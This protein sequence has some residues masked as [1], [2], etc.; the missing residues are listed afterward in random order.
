MNILKLL[1]SSG[2]IQYNGYIARKFGVSEAIVLGELCSYANMYHFQEF[3]FTQDKIRYRTA[4]SE[5]QVR[6]ALKTLESNK[7][8]TITKKGNPCK[9]WYFLHGDILAD[10]LS[11]DDSND[12]SVQTSYDKMTELDTAECRNYLRQ[13]DGTTYDK[14]TQHLK[15]NII[16][17][18][19]I[20][21]RNRKEDDSLSSNEFS[22]N[23]L[24]FKIESEGYNYSYLKSLF[25]LWK[26]NNLPVRDEIDFYNCFKNSKQFI[27]ENRVTSD[28]MISAIKNYADELKNSPFLQKLRWSF[29]SFVK[30]I[31]KFL[32]AYYVKGC[33]AP[34]TNESKE[35]EIFR[36]QQEQKREQQGTAENGLPIR[37]EGTNRE[38][39]RNELNQ[40]ITPFLNNELDYE[41]WRKD[42]CVDFKNH[43]EKYRDNEK[44]FL[45]TWYSTIFLNDV[46]ER[47]LTVKL[48]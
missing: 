13:N 20:D 35:D 48:G 14:M 41:Q 32:P 28:E 2:F 36:K 18:I 10:I 25:S 1:S 3:W 11:E 30:N 40:P 27:Q 4:L 45:T 19:N 42:L 5:R 16:D 26:E 44:Q 9:N 31:R 17:N 24:E 23:S 37:Y 22:N 21:K 12:E 46:Y 47:L 29:D 33:Y 7:I 43:P 8:L 39:V 34:F 38:I 6:Q 15:D